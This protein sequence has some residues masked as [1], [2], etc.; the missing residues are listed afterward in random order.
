MRIVL[1]ELHTHL[2][3]QQQGCDSRFVEISGQ[4]IQVHTDLFW[5]QINC[6]AIEQC[7]EYIGHVH[8]EAERG[9]SC[10]AVIFPVEIVTDTMSVCHHV[11]MFY[12]ATLG[13][14]C[15]A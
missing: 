11:A 6:T 14:T 13:Q 10:Y 12:L 3:G 5:N 9:V 8:V 1:Q 7:T 4:R 15:G 2:G